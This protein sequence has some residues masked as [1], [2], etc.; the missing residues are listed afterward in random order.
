MAAQNLNIRG[1]VCAA[2]R[3][4]PRGHRRDAGE[5]E[6]T[7]GDA[8]RPIAVVPVELPE[9]IEQPFPDDRV[10]VRWQ[11]RRQIHHTTR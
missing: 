9:K 5:H 3:A 8:L 6:A 2:T 11:E 7:K 1:F 10:G 4:Q